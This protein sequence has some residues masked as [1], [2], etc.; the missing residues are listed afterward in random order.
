MSR[1]QDPFNRWEACQTYAGKKLLQ[2]VE[3]AS[4]NQSLRTDE[5]LAEALDA[6]LADTALE[7][8]FVALMLNLPSENDLAARIGTNVDPWAIHTARSHLM[9][10]LAAALHDRLTGL[11]DRLTDNDP[12]SPAAADAGRRALRNTVLDLLSR[13]D[14]PDLASRQFRNASNMTDEMGALNVLGTI[15]AP[16]RTDA[17]NAFYDANKGDHLLV[18][19]W[20]ALNAMAP[21]PDK[22]AEIRAL[23]DHAA[24]SLKTPNKVRALVGTF[25]I[26]NPVCFNHEDGS[27]YRFLADTVLALDS[28]NPQVAARLSSAFKSWRM[29]E[30]GRSAL[31]K[32]EIERI[33]SRKGL[34]R[35]TLEIVTKTLQ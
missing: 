1:D 2:C 9:A 24:F 10:Y 8:A 32:A 13:I 12:Y 33:K 30:P 19:K 25:S 27:G 20:L 5:R 29:M 4:K 3:D 14:G 17:L 31:A 11:Y 6:C 34:S 21:F 15:D 16:E 28:L 26:A 22:I 7:P 18:D 35:D 23:T